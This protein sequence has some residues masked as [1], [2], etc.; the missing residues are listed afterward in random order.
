[1]GKGPEWILFLRR[2][3]NG[4]QVSEMV[5]AI[6]SHQEKTNQNHDERPR[7]MVAVLKKI[8]GNKYWGGVEERE[9]LCSADENV[10]WHS[11]YEKRYGASSKN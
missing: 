11:H 7:V 3:T 5:L 10:Q 8:R 2:H 6:T 4:Q 9:P 1:M